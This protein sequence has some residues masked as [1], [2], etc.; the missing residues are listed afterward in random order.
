M[1]KI[2]IHAD[3]AKAK[4]ID[5]KLYN[6]E[7]FFELCK[8]KLFVPSWQLIGDKSV[9]AEAGSAAPFTLLENY[10]DEPLLLSKDKEN[11]IRCL[12]NVCTHRGNLLVTEKCKVNQLVCKYHGRRFGMDGKFI[13]MPEFKEVENFPTESDHLKTLPLYE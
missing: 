8:E 12:S 1:E 2:F 11:K 10:L 3:I 13:S 4:T 7:K 9:L 5:T 6:D